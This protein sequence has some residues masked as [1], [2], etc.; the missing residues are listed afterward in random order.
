MRVRWVKWILFYRTG[1]PLGQ[2]LAGGPHLQLRSPTL[3]AL[4]TVLTPSGY[5]QNLSS[6]LQR[7]KSLSSGWTGSVQSSLGT[8][9]PRAISGRLPGE[10]GLRQQ[11]AFHPGI[12]KLGNC[13][14]PEAELGKLAE[15]LSRLPPVPSPVWSPAVPQCLHSPAL[16]SYEPNSMISGGVG[17]PSLS[18]RRRNS[19]WCEKGIG[20]GT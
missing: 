1:T 3:V 12:R 20:V 4:L 17:Q 13:P 15:G 9:E 6:D 2:G 7:D 16:H 10:C 5:K 19:Q 14:S 18:Q 8:P 11:R